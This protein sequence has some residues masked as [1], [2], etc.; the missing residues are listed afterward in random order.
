MS[1]RKITMFA[2]LVAAV[3]LASNANAD[4]WKFRG[5]ERLQTNQ[6]G[7]HNMLVSPA[8][9]RMSNGETPFFIDVQDRFDR[10]GILNG[11]DVDSHDHGFVPPRAGVPAGQLNAA[12]SQEAGRWTGSDHLSIAG[13]SVSNIGDGVAVAS[14][15]WLVEPTLGDDYLVEADAKI[16][17]GETVQIGYLGSADLENA[18]IGQLALGIKRLDDFTLQ[19][20]VSWDDEGQQQVFSSR[21]VTSTN[22]TEETLRLQLGWQDLRNGN[23][24]FDA[25]LGTPDG[26]TRLAQGNMLAALDV[27]DVGFLLD[28]N[29]SAID[30]FTAAVPEPATGINMLAG[31]L[32]LA[33]LVR[34]R[35]AQM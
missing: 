2:S 28:G 16:A 18:R 10:V 8:L 33:G 25:W 7:E 30:S 27:T 5:I 34:R 35:K 3:C 20:N 24:L 32:V 11:S 1:I 4:T 21:L 31:M 13:G 29:G 9:D 17:I 12:L 6:L 15:N 14:V 23:D 26:N 19:W 22:T